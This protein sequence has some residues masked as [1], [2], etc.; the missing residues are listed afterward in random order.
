MIGELETV[1]LTESLPDRG[2]VEGDLGAVVHVY[3]GGQ[4]FEVE[5]V[6]AGG[7][8]VGVLTLTIDQIRPLR[9]REILHVR[10]L[11]SPPA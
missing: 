4:S 3:P 11:A 1:A 7:E 8:T 10:E 9:P 5:F 6:T 2:L